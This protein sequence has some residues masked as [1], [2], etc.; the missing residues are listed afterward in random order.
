MLHSVYFDSDDPDSERRFK[1]LY[2]DYF[3]GS[4]NIAIGAAFSPDAIHWT[5]Y[6]QNPV[7]TDTGDTGSILNVKVN[8]KYVFFHKPKL[9][10]RSVRRIESTDFVNWP[11]KTGALSRSIRSAGHRI[12][13][14]VYFPL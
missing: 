10:V 2:F 13:W 4:R 9:P 11:R 7:Y 3:K 14:N 12:L 1:M 6:A 8:G 5:K